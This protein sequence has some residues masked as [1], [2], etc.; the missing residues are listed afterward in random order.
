MQVQNINVISLT[1]G[2]YRALFMEGTNLFLI[3]LLILLL[4]NL[5]F[6]LGSKKKN[7]LKRFLQIK[8]NE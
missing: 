7:C 5:L 3:N 6:I 2:A 1:E 8:H 4:S